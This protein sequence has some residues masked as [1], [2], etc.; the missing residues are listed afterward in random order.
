MVLLIY[1]AEEYSPNNVAKDKAILDAVG[2]ELSVNGHEVVFRDEDSVTNE[3]MVSASKV[4]SMA[5]RWRSLLRQEQVI[6]EGINKPQGVRIS[7]HSRE[8]TMELLQSAGVDVPPFWAYEPSEDRMFS[9]EPELQELLPAWVKGMNPRGVTSGDVRFVNT[10]LEADSA[11][12]EMSADGYT[13]IIVSSHVQGKVLKC[14]CVTD[15]DGQMWLKHFFPQDEGYTKFGD[16]Q[17]NAVVE[18]E[19]KTSDEMLR[20]IARKISAILNLNVFGFDSIVTTEGRVSVID[21]NDWPSFSRF[22][23]EAASHIAKLIEK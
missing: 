3:D 10:P 13:D 11:V 9:C 8:L 4:F 18:E 7:A 21:V 22:R 1:R 6:N 17:H 14:Y 20:D 5:R 15:G 16:E 19:V 2:R 12:I 23:D